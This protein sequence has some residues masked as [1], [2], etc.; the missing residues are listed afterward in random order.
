MI[1]FVRTCFFAFVFGSVTYASIQDCGL[2]KSLFNITDLAL[3]PDPPV[4]G[5]SIA[6]TFQFINPGEPITDGSVTTSVTLN[7]IPFAPSV[8]PL[9]TNTQCPLGTGFN[10]RSTKGTTPTSV[11]GKVVTKIVWAAT[12]GS[13]LACI[14]TSFSLLSS[15]GNTA[16]K[17]L[18]GSKLILEFRHAKRIH[19]MF[20]SNAKP[21]TALVVYK[22]KPIYAIEYAKVPYNASNTMCFPSEAPLLTTFTDTYPLVVWRPKSNA[23]RFNSF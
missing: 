20:R 9:C 16:R 5:S 13:Q 3:T 12:N 21:N 10:D 2:G 19:Q 8:E 22:R 17:S 11:Q 6:M 23:L 18:R 7:F 15:N 14:A 1:S 4:P